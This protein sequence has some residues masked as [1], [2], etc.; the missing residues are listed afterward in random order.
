MAAV[1]DWIKAN[2]VN[3]VNFVAGEYWGRSLVIF[4]LFVSCITLLFLNKDKIK[5]GYSILAAY[6]ILLI[7]L[8]LLDP[9]TLKFYDDTREAFALLPMCVM[10][11]CVIAVKS[12]DLQ[13]KVKT[14]AV[15]IAL[16]I[17]I[18]LAG[19]ATNIQ[20]EG[21]VD[22]VNSYKVDDQGLIAASSILEDSNY[23][24]VTVCYILRTDEYHW[25]DV[26]AYE[27]ASQYSGLINAYDSVPGEDQAWEEADYIVINNALIEADVIDVNSYV[28]V[29]NAG[30]YTVLK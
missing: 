20:G 12:K 4:I 24:P 30:S 23:E 6:S 10:I 26:S 2:I 5:R 19:L 15:I 16:S 18:S 9:L 14:N 7:V 25:T 3:V 22:S 27:V 21:L 8:V 28:T 11:A 29:V 17:L 1:Y 13:G